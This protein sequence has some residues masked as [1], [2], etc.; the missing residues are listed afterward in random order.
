MAGLNPVDRPLKPVRRSP[1]GW[2]E[3]NA[4][5]RPLADSEGGTELKPVGGRT[6]MAG[7]G[8]G[9]LNPVGLRAGMG[10]TGEPVLSIAGE[11]ARMP[12]WTGDVSRE[13]PPGRGGRP[14][15]DARG[16]GF[17][18]CKPGGITVGGRGCIQPLAYVSTCPS[19]VPDSSGGSGGVSVSSS[20]GGHSRGGA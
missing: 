5:G 13:E 10:W 2:L 12:G 8:S 14:E 6:L 9:L 20:N 16:S 17:R 7:A 19:R 11:E 15:D 18:D 1:G 4:V 3:L